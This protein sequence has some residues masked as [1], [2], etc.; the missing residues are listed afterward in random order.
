MRC[1]VTTA[2]KFPC[3]RPDVSEL[4][5]NR[6][7]DRGH[8]FDWLM[9]SG[10]PATAFATDTWGRG[11]VWIGPTATGSGLVAGLRRLLLGFRHDLR[12]Y[13]LARR[14]RYD[15][16]IVK[17]KFLAVLV[18]MVIQR[19]LGVPFIYWLSFPFP[20]SVAYKARQHRQPLRFL[21][22]VRARLMAWV[23]YRWVPA[24]ARH[25][26]VQSRW[27]QAD[28]VG[29]GIP[30]ALMTA[31]PMGV[32]MEATSAV[33][34]RRA[35][36]SPQRVVYIGAL[37]RARRLD[38]LL[39][40]FKD[41]VQRFPDAELC[42]VGA[43]SHARDEQALHDLAEE[44]GIGSNVS[45]MGQRDPEDTWDVVRSALIGVSPIPPTP[46]F[47]P[48]SPT[49]LVEYMALERAVVAN[50]IPDQKL[51]VESSGA[52][53]C[54]A[55]READ[56]SA[57]MIALLEDPERALELGRRGRAWVE[58]HRSYAAIAELTHRM[59][60]SS[61]GGGGPDTHER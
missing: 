10:R 58:Q 43:A 60:V 51:V 52:G 31:V 54:V 15:L 39:R 19:R 59:L 61:A 36:C 32:S 17:D 14:E 7:Q 46:E 37:N 1:L 3:H 57:A 41:V 24:H 27:M 47:L 45:F 11:T 33:T 8:R 55:Y 9:Q 30:E 42:F 12:L 35:T 25:V 13:G 48:S 49:K 23:L 20:E 26:M 44:L 28:L 5:V 29:K 38:F 21:D 40:A 16:V 6:L 22:V 34:A 53:R 56:F 50:D 18:A 4:F 2:D